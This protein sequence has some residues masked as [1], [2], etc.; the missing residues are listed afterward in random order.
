[1]SFAEEDDIKEQR[2]LDGVDL[3]EKSLAYRSELG[4]N[5]TELSELYAFISYAVSFPKSFLA[6]VDSYST[7]NSGVKNFLAVALVLHDLGY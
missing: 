1:M 7:M 3:L 4:W 2:I 5:Q 6:L